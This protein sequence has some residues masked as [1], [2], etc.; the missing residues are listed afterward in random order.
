MDN[1]RSSTAYRIAFAYSAVVALGVIVLG[2]AIF[3]AM[4]AAFTHQ[5][6]AIITGEGQS[7]A[8]EYR[9]EGR[10]A[11]LE[12][13]KEREASKS[14]T[15]LYYALFRADGHRVAGNLQT[16]W[17]P[18]GNHYIKFLDID[19]GP[20]DVE[21]A[22]SYAIDLDSK[23]RLV[24][25]ADRD[26]VERG[27]ET[28]LRVFG[29]GLAA[30]IVF[31]TVGAAAF[32]S[33]L[34]RRLRLISD[35][36]EAIIAGDLRERMPVGARR[37]EFDQL[38]MTLNRMLDRIEGLL[39]NLRQVSSDIAH[40]LRTPLTRLR[41]ALERGLTTDDREKD[42]SVIEDALNRVD[43][44]LSLFSA[45]LR[46]AEVESGETRRFFAPVDLSALALELAES[47]APAIHDGGRTLTSSIAPNLE[48]IGDAELL[49]QA[50][51]NLIENA[52]RHTPPGTLIRL[53]A[54]SRGRFVTLEV[55][56]NGPGVP[57]TELGRIAKRFTRLEASRNSGG[58]GLGLSL[59][60]AVAKI[61]GGKL[62][63]RNAEPGLAAI[64][65]LPV[66]ADAP[67][68]EK[69]ALAQSA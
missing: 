34:R 48:V 4:H 16:S 65:K 35:G 56:D 68:S 25:A 69:A 14:S 36:A 3:W 43:D 52:Q 57:K 12:A 18:L 39:E 8:A 32:G 10:A 61:H 63:L 6:D 22:R 59:A 2:G 7:L 42:P 23:E 64:I 31:G 1:W 5:L 40:D 49:S 67:K 47:Y 24:V 37:D 11:F 46:I 26:W 41:N 19:E 58:H 60:G 30:A 27:D 28:V 44:V 55:V 21:R 17:P 50:G 66:M 33:Y 62:I 9:V 13:I 45:I 51:I 20:N 53:T 15:V 54:A 38:A 29:V